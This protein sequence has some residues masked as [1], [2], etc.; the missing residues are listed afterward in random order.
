MCR[1]KW[2]Q[3]FFYYLQQLCVCQNAVVKLKVHLC[4]IEAE[5]VWTLVEYASL[6]HTISYSDL[7]H[8]S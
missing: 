1:K 5:H 3:T 8:A 2:D 7:L 4:D 6:V